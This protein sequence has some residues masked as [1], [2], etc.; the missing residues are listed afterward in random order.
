MGILSV[1]WFFFSVWSYCMVCV[2]LNSVFV[3]SFC[4]CASWAWF[5]GAEMGMKESWGFALW[6][7]LFLFYICIEREKERRRRRRSSICERGCLSWYLFVLSQVERMGSF[8]VSDCVRF[9]LFAMDSNCGYE[10]WLKSD[11]VASRG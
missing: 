8:R 7:V 1:T 11:S 9:C 2:C 10:V 6:C 5:D 3:L 4:C